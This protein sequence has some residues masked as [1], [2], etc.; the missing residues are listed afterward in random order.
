[1]RAWSSS[2]SRGLSGVL[3]ASEFSWAR[4]D[5]AKKQ[6]VKTIAGRI[7]LFI[8]FPWPIPC[9]E[10]TLGIRITLLGGLLVRLL[11]G[12]LLIRLLATKDTKNFVQDAGFL[13]L[14]VGSSRGAWRR[15]LRERPGSHTGR[16]SIVG[17]CLIAAKYA[18]KPRRRRRLR[19]HAP[20]MQFAELG[21]LGAGEENLLARSRAG[22]RSKLQRARID[23]HD[24]DAGR[25][26]GIG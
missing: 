19:Q 10:S 7:N 20:T 25:G 24:A 9:G 8:T 22:R 15:G 16:R 2:L 1:M 23:L 17:L 14:V 12:G 4:S 26:E 11:V 18:G 6:K 5:K 21:R 3:A 13:F